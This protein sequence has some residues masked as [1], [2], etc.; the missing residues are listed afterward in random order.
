[1]RQWVKQKLSNDMTLIFWTIIELEMF[2]IKSLRI[3]KTLNISCIYNDL[4]TPLE[5]HA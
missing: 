1:M 2:L 4:K 5:E 3:H